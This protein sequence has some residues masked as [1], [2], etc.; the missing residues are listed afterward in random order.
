MKGRIL[1]S[2]RSPPRRSNFALLGGIESLLS[3]VVADSMRAWRHRSNCE[4]AAQGAA[5]MATSAPAPAIAEA[6]RIV[7]SRIWSMS[8]GSEVRQH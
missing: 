4:L 1:Y 7:P 5:N 8:S 3:A 2:G 6:V